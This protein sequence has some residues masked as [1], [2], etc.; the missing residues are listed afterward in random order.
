V[1]TLMLL[2]P[3]LTIV[4]GCGG[5]RERPVP[6]GGTVMFNKKPVEGAVVTF[7]SKGGGRSASGKTAADGTFKLTSIN[8]NDG[9]VPGEYMITIAKQ[10]MKGAEGGGGGVDISSG[11]YGAA[12]AA[13]MA[14]AG[15]NQMS[16]LMKDQLPKKYANAAES[17][18]T[19]TVVKGEDNNFAFELE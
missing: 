17:G 13:G 7:I 11:D 18:L 1:R 16:K 4:A 8:P 6:T 10:E 5:G 14:A 2:V 15:T 19:R 3:L 12:Y 9:A